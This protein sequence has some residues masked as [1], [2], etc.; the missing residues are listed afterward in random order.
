M[1]ST[2]DANLLERVIASYGHIAH[3]H[4]LKE[5]FG[6]DKKDSE[7]RQRVARLAKQGWLVR[8]KKGLYVVVS[9]ITSLAEN[10]V[11]LLRIS[12]A[13]NH[14]SYVSLSS[15]FFH[16]GLVDQLLT[17][18]TAITNQKTRKFRFQDFT[19][20][21][22]KVREDFYFGFSESRVEGKLVRIA[23]LEKVVLDYLYLK[24]DAYSL[25]LL[26]EKISE[27]ADRFDFSKLR[28]YALRCNLRLRRT[29][30]FLLD[31]LEADARQLHDSITEHRGYSL[32][33]SD[34]A[35]FD[36]KWRLYY[37][38]RVI[39]QAATAAS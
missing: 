5:V 11:S 23:D 1:L 34:S 22:S 20:T 31:L 17:T 27:N 4:E 33:T 10:N 3:F 19:F 16:Y 8:I 12:N 15:A 29:T 24:N 38:H 32:M 7:I 37:D 9:D 39:E 26:W 30:G 2:K 14:D 36:T 28:D 35:T 18:V 25:N 21:F 6:D 13:L